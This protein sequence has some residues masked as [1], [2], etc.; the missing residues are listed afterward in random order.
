MTTVDCVLTDNRKAVERCLE[1]GTMESSQGEIVTKKLDLIL[2][3]Q[4]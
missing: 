1:I 4:R 2:P 3:H